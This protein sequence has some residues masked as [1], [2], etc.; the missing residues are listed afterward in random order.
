MDGRNCTGRTISLLNSDVKMDDQNVSMYPPIPDA[1]IAMPSAYPMPPQ[2]THQMVPQ[3]VQPV[4]Y[5]SS[6]SPSSEPSRVS[7][8]SATSNAKA[9]PKKN[10][11]PCPLAKQVGCSD[12]FTTSGHAARHA[13]KHTGKKDAFCPECNKAFTRKDNMEQHRRTHQSGRGGSRSATTTGVDAAAKVKK[14]AKPVTKKTAVKAEQQF[15]AAIEQQLA[16]AAGQES[17]NGMPLATQPQGIVIPQPTMQQVL[18][19]QAMMLPPS[20]PYFLGNTIDTGPIPSLPM[21]MPDLNGRPPLMRNNF[22]TSLE[23][24][25]P[26]GPILSDPDAL[27]Y[28]YPSPGLSNGLNSLALAASE[29]RRWSEEKSMS[30]SPK[31][32]PS[33]ETP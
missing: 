26:M 10:Q 28:A 1:T 12:F 19:D 2:M 25:P 13:K 27:H 3:P 22:T 15:G 16:E 24:V 33:Q 32:S 11:Y 21:A 30:G 18:V 7:N 23:Y 9:Q 4:A 20:G 8:L 14:P 6:N 5:R 31:E 29:H 17:L